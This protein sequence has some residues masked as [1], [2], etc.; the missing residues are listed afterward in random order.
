MVTTKG[1]T[2]FKEAAISRV[3]VVGLVSGVVV[4]VVPEVVPPVEGSLLELS[5]SILLTVKVLV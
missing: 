4:V 5:V 1:L 2:S 3:V